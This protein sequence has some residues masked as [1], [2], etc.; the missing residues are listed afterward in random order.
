M[1]R[2]STREMPVIRYEHH[3]RTVAVQEHLRGK[4]RE[5]CLCFICK[6]F[7]IEDR[8]K[9]CPIANALYRFD[10]LAGITTPV[11]ECETFE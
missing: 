8:E 4:H 9:N 2:L 6:K 5:N 11:W 7:N 10:I 3:G 1:E